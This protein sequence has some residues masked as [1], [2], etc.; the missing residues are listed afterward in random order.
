VDHVKGADVLEILTL[1]A[2][3]HQHSRGLHYELGVGGPVIDKPDLDFS[4]HRQL[5]Q[6]KEHFVF[7]IASLVLDLLR[8]HFVLVSL[9]VDGPVDSLQVCDWLIARSFLQEELA[10][11]E[12][13]QVCLEG[14]TT[15]FLALNSRLLFLRLFAWLKEH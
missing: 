5:V 12:I 4:D 2:A 7:K 8:V 10:F 6:L 3:L 14:V 11:C 1:S 9:P 13:N 15:F